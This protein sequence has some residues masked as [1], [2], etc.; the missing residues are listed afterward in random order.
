M[1]KTKRKKV[2]IC[3]S[4]RFINEMKKWQK[5]LE[6]QG[7]EVEV[8]RLV[9][10]HKVRDKDGDLEKFEE[11]KRR[12]SR[13]HFEKIKAADVVL[14]LNYDK[15]GNKNYIGGNSFAEIAYA[16]ALN[17]CHGRKIKIY[18]INPLPPE[19]PYYE[20]LSAWQIGQW[21]AEDAED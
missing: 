13:N 2:V 17:F 9:D 4:M 19:V 1:P 10:F 21:E 15:D 8:P 18:T 3:G 7:Y 20:E 5:K 16:I 6:S 14:V 11:I 12:E